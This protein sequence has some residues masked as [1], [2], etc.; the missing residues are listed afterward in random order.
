[1]IFFP[2]EL[3]LREECRDIFNRTA[4]KLGL[5]ILTWRKVPVKP[6][7]IG[8]TALSVEPVMEQ[9]FITC[10]DHITDPLVFERKLFVLRNHA[11][12]IINNTVKKGQYWFFYVASLSYKLLSTKANLQATRCGNIFLI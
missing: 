11:C 7:G 5:E 6:S 9:V 8:P 1:V 10:P 12:H 4:E 3:K 2:K